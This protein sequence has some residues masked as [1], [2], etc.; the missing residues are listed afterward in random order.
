MGT[1][2]K[3]FVHEIFTHYNLQ[4]L[5]IDTNVCCENIQNVVGV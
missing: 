3:A 4:V 2:E 1:I 5:G